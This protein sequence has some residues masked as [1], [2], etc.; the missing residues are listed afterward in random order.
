MIRYISVAFFVTLLYIVNC[1]DGDFSGDYDYEDHYS[2]D[3]DAWLYDLEECGQVESIGTF[4]NWDQTGYVDCIYHELYWDFYSGGV[5]WTTC[6]E[7][8][9]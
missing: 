7:G 6:P 1:Q 2:K 5:N 8:K 3:P 4:C 9:L